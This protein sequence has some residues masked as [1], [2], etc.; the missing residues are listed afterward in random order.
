[1]LSFNG[2]RVWIFKGLIEESYFGISKFCHVIFFCNIYLFGK[3][4]A[5]SLN[6]LKLLILAVL[7]EEDLST[8]VP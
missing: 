3:L 6:G 1:M 5:S 4:H 2:R 7:F 8:V